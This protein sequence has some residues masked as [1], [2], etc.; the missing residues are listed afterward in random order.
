M[1]DGAIE[2]GCRAWVS[3]DVSRV[4]EQ[5]IWEIPGQ[6]QESFAIL[7]LAWILWLIPLH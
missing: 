3:C 1:R 6:S 2:I 5:V 4:G 7:I